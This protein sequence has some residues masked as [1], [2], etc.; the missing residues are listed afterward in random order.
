MTENKPMKRK[1]IMQSFAPLF[2]ILAIKNWSCE[3][4]SSLAELAGYLKKGQWSVLLRVP[5][6]PL[7]FT[8]LLEILCI[9]WVLYALV[10]LLSFMDLQTADFRSQGERLKEVKVISDSGVTFFMTYVLPMIWDNVGTLQGFFIFALLM[11]MLYGLMWRTNLYCQ[12]PVLTILGYDVVSFVFE[13]TELREFQ[14]KECIGLTRGKIEAGVEIKRQYIADNV[15][16]IYQADTVRGG[17][18][19]MRRR[20][21]RIRG[22]H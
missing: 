9:G 15:F 16:L 1:L 10:S 7:F 3:M 14:E 18:E 20:N 17:P 21:A 6:H 19:R 2:L 22:E 8:W 13:D 11:L 4:F 12:N 5:C